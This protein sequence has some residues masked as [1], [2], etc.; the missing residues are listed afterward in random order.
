MSKLDSDRLLE[1]TLSI[2]TVDLWISKLS[3]YPLLLCQLSEGFPKLLFMAN[4]LLPLSLSLCFILLLTSVLY[5]PLQMLLLKEKLH[6]DLRAGAACPP[7]SLHPPFLTANAH[8]ARP[9]FELSRGSG[10]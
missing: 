1:K 4:W 8:F 2:C 6:Q 10:I 3:S 5:F 9:A 7:S